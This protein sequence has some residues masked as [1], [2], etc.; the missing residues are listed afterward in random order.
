MSLTKAYVVY[1]LYGNKYYG[2][3][4]CLLIY[5]I[6]FINLHHEPDQ[7]Q[8]DKAIKLQEEQ[9]KKKLSY[10]NKFDSKEEEQLL[11]FYNNT[12]KKLKIGHSKCSIN[13]YHINI[14]VKM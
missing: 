7:E 12:V 8:N 3:E 14:I 1:W 9:T 13:F 11:I 2:D 5:F 6:T 10:L 4:N